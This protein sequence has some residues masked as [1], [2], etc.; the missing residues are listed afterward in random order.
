M[1][2]FTTVVL[3][4]ATKGE[5]SFQPFVSSAIWSLGLI[6]KILVRIIREGST[7]V[8]KTIN[9]NSAKQLR[10]PMDSAPRNRRA[11]W[12]LDVHV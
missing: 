2:V 7:L 8:M 3:P 9:A 10:T 11:E 6:A 4:W 1:I 5:G 12:L